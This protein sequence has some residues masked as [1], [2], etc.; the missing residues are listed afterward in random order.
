MTLEEAA[1]KLT[2]AGFY[3]RRIKSPR[4][5]VEGI[6]GSR[7]VVE[8]RPAETILVGNMFLIVKEGDS[9]WS[10]ELSTGEIIKQ[11]ISLEEVVEAILSHL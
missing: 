6:R 2:E 11:S 9:E 8:I 7:D 3:I 4:V 1:A 5:V 10:G